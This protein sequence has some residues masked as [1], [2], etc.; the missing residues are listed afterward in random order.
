MNPGNVC[1]L[2]RIAGVLFFLVVGALP[3]MANAA[4]T[5]RFGKIKGTGG[6]SS[7][8]GAGGGGLTPW[9][10]LSSY[11]EDGQLGGTVFVSRARVDDY[12]LDV[13]G[14]AFNFHD[15]AEFS[16]ARQDF[17]IEA[18]DLHI[19][20][21]RLGL[22]YKLAGDVIYDRLPQITVGVEHGKLRDETVA[23]SVGARDTQGTEYTVSI[24]RAWLNGL[25]NRTTLLNVNFRYGNANQFGILGYGGDDADRRVNMEVAGAVFLTR[26]VAIGFEYRQ[27][28]DNL[29]AIKEDSARDIFIA[30]FPNKRVSL[31]A[32]WLDLGDIAGAP[33]QRGA[34]ISLQANL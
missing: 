28:P 19:R 13:Y 2:N 20:Q 1:D 7:I 16:Y 6:V 25:A 23:L 30:Y 17:V 15:K 5:G 11:A 10:T 34:Y 22:R 9:A 4:E 32:A 14:G 12:Q 8:S 21:D 33:D 18:A 26:S 3:A 27:K 24:A 29:S 31:T